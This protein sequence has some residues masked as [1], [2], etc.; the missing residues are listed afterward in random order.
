[1]ISM[2]GFGRAIFDSMRYLTPI[3]R[4]IDR[5]VRG[6]VPFAAF[7]MAA[8]LLGQIG[9]ADLPADHHPKITLSQIEE[10]R[11]MDALLPIGPDSVVARYRRYEPETFY[12]SFS[13]QIAALEIFIDSLN[14]SIPTEA[15]I[16]TLYVD[17][18]FES[19]GEAAIR[20]TTLWLSS[21]FMYMFDDRRVVLSVVVHEFGHIVYRYLTPRER[22]EI[23][24]I[25]WDMSEAA[26][27]YLLQD[28]EYSGNAHFGGHPS[29]SPA[30]LFASA[31][32]VLSRNKE[33]FNA[34]MVYVD[35]SHFELLGTLQ[36][37]V[38]T[39]S[40][41]VAHH[42]RDVIPDGRKLFPK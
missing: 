25:W 34:R 29:D 7:A 17:H 9:C 31:Y 19:L 21:S 41:R 36:S 27:F 6:N 22:D 2:E 33:E 30:E 38:Q 11:L 32:N 5:S 4:S 37:L 40:T 18:S 20:G 15:R 24:S 23:E 14:Q 10:L 39:A 42:D 1:M 8:L 13:S 16:D 28:G 35:S 12:R 3:M 26:L